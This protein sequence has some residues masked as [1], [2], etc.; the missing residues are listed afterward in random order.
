MCSRE[1]SSEG[2]Q[3][4]AIKEQSSREERGERE[5]IRWDPHVR[6]I[7]TDLLGD[8]KSISPNASSNVIGIAPIAPYFGGV[9]LVTARYALRKTYKD[10]YM[11]G[12]SCPIQIT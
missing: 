9:V 7:E 10:T 1:E 3:Q 12:D 4:R 11:Y 2:E 8:C 6:G 5:E